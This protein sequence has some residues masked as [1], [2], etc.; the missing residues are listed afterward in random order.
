MTS[1][2]LFPQ[3]PIITNF[4][5]GGRCKEL[6]LCTGPHFSTQGNFHPEFWHFILL[7][8][9]IFCLNK[10]T[11]KSIKGEGESFESCSITIKKSQSNNLTTIRHHYTLTKMGTILKDGQPQLFTKMQN[12]QNSLENGMIASNEVNNRPI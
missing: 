6:V 8:L 10:Q 11:D 2:V 9:F 3:Q 1:P 4:S 5:E 7:L 12:K